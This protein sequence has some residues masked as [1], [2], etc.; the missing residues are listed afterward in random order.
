MGNLSERTYDIVE[1]KKLCKAIDGKWSQASDRILT[2]QNDLLSFFGNMRDNEIPLTILTR[3]HSINEL[4]GISKVMSAEA[5]IGLSH[6]YACLA[7]IG[8]T[9][10]VRLVLSDGKGKL[11]DQFDEKKEKNLIIFGQ[12]SQGNKILYR[13]SN[14]MIRYRESKQEP[15]YSYEIKGN[16]FVP[17]QDRMTFLIYKTKTEASNTTLALFSPWT[18]ANGLAAKYFAENFWTFVNKAREG[19]FLNIYGVEEVG[20][21][22]ELIL[23]E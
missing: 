8:K 18:Y 20:K 9:Q 19:E 22:P 14:G 13:V 2:S 23:S 5:A 7:E 1:W 15:K 4:A 17:K 11:S 10:G 16:I 3:S 12:T 21:T 6:I